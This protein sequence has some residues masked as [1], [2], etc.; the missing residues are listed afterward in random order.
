MARRRGLVS[1]DILVAPGSWRTL[2]PRAEGDCLTIS[3]EGRQ[4]PQA[5]E[6]LFVSPG[7]G[8]LRTKADR[9]THF[10]RR[11]TKTRQ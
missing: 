8:V 7:R 9:I 4:V 2:T 5:S 6:K 10:D 3:F 11:E 1:A